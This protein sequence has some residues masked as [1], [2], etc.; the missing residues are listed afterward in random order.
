[1]QQVLVS[2]AIQSQLEAPEHLQAPSSFQDHCE[3]INV[4]PIS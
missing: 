3:V 4:S 1:M 2:L